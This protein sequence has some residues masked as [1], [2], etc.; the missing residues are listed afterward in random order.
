MYIIRI[1]NEVNDTIGMYSTPYEDNQPIVEE[2]IRL[3]TIAIEQGNEE[4]IE[5]LL[6]N[7]LSLQDIHRVFFNEIIQIDLESNGI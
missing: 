6:N 2:A 4:D 5:V 3:A 7:Y 1:L